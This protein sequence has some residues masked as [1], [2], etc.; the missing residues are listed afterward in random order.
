MKVTIT[1]NITNYK[2][3]I[4]EPKSGSRVLVNPVINTILKVTVQEPKSSAR[5]FI[6]NTQTDY[7]VNIQELK[8]AVRVV[9]TEKENTPVKVTIA[10]LGERGIAGNNGLQGIQGE[11]GNE[12][13]QGIEGAAGTDGLQGIQGADGNVGDQGPQGIQ[14]YAGED[15]IQGESGVDGANGSQGIQGQQGIQGESG[16]DGA[17]GSQGIQGEKGIQGDP[18]QD[19]IQ[20]E[21]GVD[22][23]NGSQGIQGEQGIQG[24]S[25]E[26]GIQGESGVDGIN[27]TD[28][29]DKTSGNHKEVSAD[30]Q[31]LATD[32]AVKILTAGNS[33]TLATLGMS[34][35]IQ[36]FYIFNFSTGDNTIVGF[37]DGIE[38][39]VIA[40]DDVIG[41]FWN[42]A[43]YDLM[44]KKKE[45]E[46]IS[47]VG[48]FSDFFSIAIDAQDYN[49][50]PTD[51]Y[52]IAGDYRLDDINAGQTE[53]VSIKIPQPAFSDSIETQTESTSFKFRVW[54][55]GSTG[56]TTPANADGSNNGT[57][58]TLRTAV[59]GP[60]TITLTSQLGINVPN[61]TITSAIYRGWFKSVN[62]LTTSFGRIFLV[63]DGALF[64]NK[65]MINNSTVNTTIDSLDGSFTYDLIANGI[66]TIEKIQSISL[67]HNTSDVAAGLSPHVMTVDAGC[68]ELIVIL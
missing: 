42:G 38:N 47:G 13:P 65:I 29:V 49:A 33:I 45:D 32:E 19:G 6:T 56:G 5:V 10:T 62:I 36:K 41:L 34:T 39:I 1:E 53:T 58:A 50:T 14:G 3:T 4:Q 12:G 16:V 60:S 18:G 28:G 11:Q 51:N 46:V 43:S 8:A 31:I 66:D 35:E 24:D 7:Q 59:A 54:L 20:G 30:Y 27:G 44:F 68:I 40:A 67:R 48:G 2:V 23:A 26:D 61:L 9:V 15:G 55:S 64:A 17:N 63:S 21:S 52:S 25:G 57:V 37:I 22:G